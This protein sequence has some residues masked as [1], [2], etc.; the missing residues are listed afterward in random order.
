MASVVMSSKY[1]VVVP[2]EVRERHGFRP[3]DRLVWFESPSGLKLIKPLTFD[4]MGGILAGR[5]LPPF[6]REKDYDFGETS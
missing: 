2:K 6:V 3:G 4:E 5:N 1:Q